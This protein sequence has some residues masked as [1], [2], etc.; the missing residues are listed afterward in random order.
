MLGI[1]H[2]R[3][4]LSPRISQRLPFQRLTL[5]A[6]LVPPF[7]S[8]LYH[9]LTLSSETIAVGLMLTLD[10]WSSDER[11]KTIGRGLA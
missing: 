4:I 1:Q 3:L 10:I 5:P 11:C 8:A 7:G 9:R 6:K 2:P